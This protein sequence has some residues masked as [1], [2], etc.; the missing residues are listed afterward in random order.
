LCTAYRCGLNSKT[1]IV[2]VQQTT[3]FWL[4]KN[5]K[6][7]IVVLWLT[8]S[9]QVR[10]FSCITTMNMQFYESHNGWL[11][12]CCIGGK[13][14]G[15]C[16]TCAIVTKR[17]RGFCSFVCVFGTVMYVIYTYKRQFFTWCKQPV[18]IVLGR[19]LYYINASFDHIYVIWQQLPAMRKSLFLC[20][21]YCSY[22]R[23]FHGNWLPINCVQ[24]AIVVHCDGI[25]ELN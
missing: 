15:R 7:I 20:S 22:E 14:I 18:C 23:E 12:R 5:C 3:V 6:W 10:C 4:I 1:I 11:M 24:L 16:W 8:K 25:I 9:I 2:C 13:S 21:G 17:R 19:E